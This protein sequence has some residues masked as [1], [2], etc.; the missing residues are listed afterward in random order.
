VE[1]GGIRAAVVCIPLTALI[2]AGPTVGADDGP[3]ADRL[4]QHGLFR[5]PPADRQVSG[6]RWPPPFT[7]SARNFVGQKRSPALTIAVFPAAAPAARHEL[8][9]AQE[10]ARAEPGC[11]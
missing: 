10:K 8:L 7:A 6:R 3:G 5:A 4:G 2:G 1:H 9:V 11:G